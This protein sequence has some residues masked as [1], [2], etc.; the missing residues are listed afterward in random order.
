MFARR[1][2]VTWRCIMYSPISFRRRDPTSRP[3]GWSQSYIV[4]PIESPVKWQVLVIAG[5][6]AFVAG[7]LIGPDGASQP[8]GDVAEEAR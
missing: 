7:R 5:V 4:P 1:L 2:L 8:R 3:T 6:L